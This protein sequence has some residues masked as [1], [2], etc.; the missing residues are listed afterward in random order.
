MSKILLAFSALIFSLSFAAYGDDAG[1]KAYKRC[2]ACHLATGK[3]V[4]GAFPPVKDRLVPF[5][6][7]KEGRD[8]L[9]MVVEA[10]LMGPIKVNGMTYRSVMPAQG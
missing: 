8:Y 1:A 10:G 7:Y 2:S 5:A 6:N 9:I 4:P 3:G